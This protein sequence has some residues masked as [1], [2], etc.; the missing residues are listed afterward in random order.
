[1]PKEKK[2]RVLLILPPQASTALRAMM[3]QDMQHNKTGF[4][5]TLIA[6]EF[7]RR[8]LDKNAAGILDG[9]SDDAPKDYTNDLPKNR[10]Y[11]GRMV[12]QQE[13]EDLRT[14]SIALKDELGLHPQG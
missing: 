7:R 14:A 8:K 4:I 3:A 2:E 5:T 11:F 10:P 1:M 9:D 6:Q 12:G 13:Y